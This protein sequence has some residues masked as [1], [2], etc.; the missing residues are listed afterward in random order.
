MGLTALL[1]T[2]AAIV[3]SSAPDCGPGRCQNMAAGIAPR[4]SPPPPP[5]PTEPA[6]LVVTPAAGAT[7]V[8][9][10]DA[11]RVS[12]VTGR[13]DAVS[14]VNDDGR[15]IPG[16]LAPDG[17]SWAPSIPLGY[18]RTY[19][20]TLAGRGPGG[21]PTRQTSSFTTVDPT[22]QTQVYLNTVG[23]APIQDGGTYG[24]GMIVVAHFDEPITD[25]AAAERHLR[26]TTEPRTLGSWYWTDDQ[27][28][29]WRPQK[30]YAPGTRV[31][32]SA[33]VYGTKLGDGLYGEQDQR[34]GFTIGDS[35][36]SV[37]DDVTKQVTVYD[38]GQVVRT[39]PTSMGM[40]GTKTFGDRT[41]SFWTPPGVYSVIGKANPVV[42]DSST[43]GLPVDSSLGYR[44]TIPWATQISGDGIYLHQLNATIWAQGNTDTSHGCLNLSGDNAKW[45]YDFSIPGDIVEVRNTGGPPLRLDQNG[46]WTMP[47]EQWTKGSA[48]HD[49]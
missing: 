42:M 21:M 10:T 11:V 23:Y 32:V 22:S 43:F 15:E 3:A 2:T 14:M 41:L 44:E 36:V 33:D 27:T 12:A 6:K 29:H 30:Y 35:H 26:V 16:A 4:P 19:T 20:V 40:G 8:S 13:I 5:S 24:V 9:P 49:E 18:G 48:L 25:K 46:D 37:A 45:F 28:A 38:N 47:W 31:D 39:M 17:T 1:V 7:D 34:V